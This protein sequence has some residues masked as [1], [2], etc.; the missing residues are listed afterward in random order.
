MFRSS[1]FASLWLD[2]IEARWPEARQRLG[3]IALTVLLEIVL[4]FVLLSLGTG[5]ERHGPSTEVVATFDARPVE[6]VKPKQSAAK[7]KPAAVARPA[8]ADHVR[9]PSVFPPPPPIA[10][11]RPPTAPP[12]LPPAPPAEAPPAP[13]TSKIRA[14]IRSD[15]AGAPGPADDGGRGGSIR[16]GSLG[17]PVPMVKRSMPRNGILTPPMTTSC[18][19]ISRWST[20]RPGH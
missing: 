4:L 6:E 10:L 17:R 3:P 7:P 14:V 15:M 20:R 11:P 13:A 1:P 9:P 12:V 19:A 18:A 8:P 2:A 16:S 5:A